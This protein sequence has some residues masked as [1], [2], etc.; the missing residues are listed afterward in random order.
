MIGGGAGGISVASSLLKRQPDLRIA[1][2]EPADH[3]F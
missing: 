1:V 3:H 2:V